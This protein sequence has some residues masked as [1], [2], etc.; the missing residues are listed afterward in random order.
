MPIHAGARGDPIITIGDRCTLGKG[1]GIVGHERIEIGDDI[2][3]GHYVYITDQNHGYED[4]STAD[5]HAD[6]EERAGVDRIGQLARPRRVVLPGRARRRARR[7]AA[8]AVVADDVPDNCVVA[9]VPARVV[10]RYAD[11]D[12]WVRDVRRDEL[13]RLSRLAPGGSGTSLG[14]QLGRRRVEPGDRVGRVEEL[15]RRRSASAREEAAPVV[16]EAVHA[17]A[18]VAGLVLAVAFGSHQIRFRLSRP[19]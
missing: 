18:D 9:G 13:S 11:G 14:V 2:W 4:V 17:V 7:V 12:G 3:T 8:G 5:R 10:R 19:P 1:I 6:V 16:D 15:D